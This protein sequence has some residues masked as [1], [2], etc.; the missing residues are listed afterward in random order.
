M[1]FLRRLI[2]SLLFTTC[3]GGLNAQ[4]LVGINGK[5]TADKASFNLGNIPVV[6]KADSNLGGGVDTL[7]TNNQGYFSDSLR[8]G[9]GQKGALTAVVT[10]CDNKQRA[11]TQLVVVDSLPPDTFRL[12]VCPRR[13]FRIS[14][15]LVAGAPNYSL[16]NRPVIFET[17]LKPG[18]QKDT[19][20][21]NAQGAFN[22][23]IWVPP[24]A[25][26]SV[27]ITVTNCQGKRITRKQRVNVANTG[28]VN[29]TL[30]VCRQDTLNVLGRLTTDDPD[31]D[32]EGIRVT[33]K[34]EFLGNPRTVTTVSDSG[35]SF[36]RSLPVPASA[37][38][39]IQVGVKTCNGDQVTK[40]R[41]VNVDT[42][43]QAPFK[44]NACPVL[45]NL[46]L[47]GSVVSDQGIEADARV[48]LYRQKANPLGRPGLALVDSTGVDNQGRYDFKGLGPDT[49]HVRARLPANASNSERYMPTY[50][51]KDTTEAGAGIWPNAH[52]RVLHTRDRYQT[53]IRL[54]KADKPEGPGFI[55]GHL[56]EEN[57]LGR[58]VP[59]PRTMVVL[60]DQSG[61]ALTHQMTDS[62]GFFEFPHLALGTYQIRVEV[63]G[64]PSETEN[65]TLTEEDLSVSHQNFRVKNDSIVLAE[66]SSTAIEQSQI[67][68]LAVY[69][70][71]V[72]SRV[73]LSLAKPLPQEGLLILRSSRGRIIRRRPIREGSSATAYE[74]G[75]EGLSNGIYL[76]QI[77]T[78]DHVIN[79]K[80]IKQ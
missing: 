38:D 67:P 12:N 36:R 75:L 1:P 28:Q 21:T 34:T 47:A 35:G 31:Y 6:V 7:Y 76:L 60:L 43:L 29:F 9:S 63:P 45:A 59:V 15:Q 42:G 54:R 22:T 10:T 5:L 19:L 40:T 41:L 23:T 4:E 66:R 16:S 64:K 44:L 8:F 65:L 39:S 25:E 37:K 57:N 2:I 17:G 52:F 14:G 30:N 20:Y 11:D 77:K 78:G 58:K 62:V 79:R 51:R 68:Q 55:T 56:F 70:N 74:L 46:T 49:Y 24:A 13:P 73:T 27:T 3:L 18:G 53:R 61:F 69:P 71:P 26:D 32:L 50:F 80:L 33:I 48:M 72:Q